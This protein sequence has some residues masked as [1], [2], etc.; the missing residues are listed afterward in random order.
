[1]CIFARQ[2]VAVDP[3]FSNLDLISCRNL[4]IYLG[5]TLQRKVMPLFHYALKSNGF[6]VLG[7][8]ETVG[9]FS[10]LFALV[11]RKTRSYTKKATHLRRAVAF[12]HA[13]PNPHEAAGRQQPTPSTP[14]GPS[15]TDLQKQADRI[16]LTNYCP[17]GVIITGTWKYSSSA[18]VPARSSNTPTAKRALTCSEWPA[19]A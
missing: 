10:D 3:P 1:M 12:G 8:S 14:A 2:N 13:S 4:L 17:P 9:G 16:L 5:A 6:L 15:L 18:G 19:R 11:D 7:A